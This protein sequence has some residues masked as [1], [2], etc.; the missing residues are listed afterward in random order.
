MLAEA[1]GVPFV[2]LNRIV[3]RI[4]GCDVLEI[5]S[6]YGSEAYRRYEQRALDEAIVTFPKAVIATA[7]GLVSE[8]GTYRAAAVPVLHR[9]AAC[10]PGGAHAAGRRPGRYAT[11]GR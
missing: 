4:A 1:L 3:E 10:I 11:D 2:E 9:L 8:P 5:H 7:G 6:L